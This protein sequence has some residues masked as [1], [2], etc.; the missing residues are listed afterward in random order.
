MN[1]GRTFIPVNVTPPT[2]PNGIAT[3][4][5]F[6]ADPGA[7]SIARPSPDRRALP[8]LG[9]CEGGRLA[10]HHFF[11]IDSVRDPTCFINLPTRGRRTR[12]PRVVSSVLAPSPRRRG[13]AKESGGPP[14]VASTLL[15]AAK[16]ERV[17]PE[18]K[19][20]TDLPRSGPP[21]RVL[22]SIVSSPSLMA[23][24]SSIH[25]PAPTIR[26]RR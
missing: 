17:Q 12:P 5:R 7:R 13:A 26:G 10:H 8:V 4:T 25:R 15:Y 11:F 16:V 22:G 19:A 6:S 20:R 21:G 24:V 3:I 2:M 14:I 18:L 9:R 23:I 1:S